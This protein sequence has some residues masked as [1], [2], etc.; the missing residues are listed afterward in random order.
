MN[1]ISMAITIT[2]AAQVLVLAE[3][4]L[5]L[6]I[7]CDCLWF[8][9]GWAYRVSQVLNFWKTKNLWVI[10]SLSNTGSI[11][12]CLLMFWEILHNKMTSGT[13]LVISSVNSITTSYLQALIPINYRL[14]PNRKVG[15]GLCSPIQLLTPDGIFDIIL[16]W[17]YTWADDS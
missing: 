13:I 15:K 5:Y 16:S 17:K 8:C 4:G 7:S 6:G 9:L 10:C 12:Y 11:I 14:K 2:S 1:H 3:V